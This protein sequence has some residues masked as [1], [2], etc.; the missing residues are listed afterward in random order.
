MR[1]GLGLAVA[2][3]LVL[4]I[5]TLVTSLE[6]VSVDEELAYDRLYRLDARR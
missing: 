4:R 1:L 2:E 6:T 5:T 3:F